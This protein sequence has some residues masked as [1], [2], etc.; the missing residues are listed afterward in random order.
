M[1]V[2][3][4]DCAGT[5]E[6]EASNGIPS[7]SLG[8]AR[9]GPGQRLVEEDQAVR[10]RPL[11]DPG[12]A[13]RLLVE[14]TH[15]GPGQLRAREVGVDGIYRTQPSAAGRDVQ[16][17]LEEDVCQPHRAGVGRLPGPV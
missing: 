1:Q 13:L 10:R 9:G 3:D 11:E 16:P 14:P 2:G 7:E 8:L 4:V 12:Q 17:R 5:E 6:A 15:T